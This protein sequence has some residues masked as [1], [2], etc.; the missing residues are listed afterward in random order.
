MSWSRSVT[1]QRS[2]DDAAPGPVWSVLGQTYPRVE[3]IVVDD[4]STDG[5][6]DAV[7]AFGDRV[8]YLRKTNGGVAS[9][10]NTG[11]AAASGEYVA[12]LDADDLWKPEKLDR[13]MALFRARPDLGL[14][15]TAAETVDE[16]L[17]PLGLID[18]PEGAVALRNTLLLELPVMAIT[19]TGVVPA[20]V[21]RELGG[22][23]ERLST[24]ADLDFSCRVACAYPV[25]RVDEPLALYRQHGS[26]MHLNTRAMER[27]MSAIYERVFTS[28]R[29]P[30]ELRPLQG[31]AYANLEMTL[32]LSYRRESWA[33]ALA[34]LVRAFRHDTARASVLIWGGL[35]RRGRRLLGDPRRP[36]PATLRASREPVA[37][38]GS[39]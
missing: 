32:A 38:G 1:R 18:A 25:A 16:H 21:Y 22:F 37:V 36:A 35:A 29:L 39:R 23:D 28:E 4:G 13:Q 8:H 30:R 17:E 11:A 20:R 27:D 31:R 33:R 26:Q 12:F 15:Y 2:D 14:V 9:A 7:R 34:H 3:C 6:A 24:S 19:M 10:R 5:T